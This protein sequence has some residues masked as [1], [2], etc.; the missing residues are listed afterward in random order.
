MIRKITDGYVV[1]VYDDDGNPVSQELVTADF[2]EWERDS[3]DGETENIDDPSGSG[4][5]K[6][7]LVPFEMIQPSDME[8]LIAQLN[9]VV[10]E[11]KKS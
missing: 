4:N 10:T 5:G 2:S 9:P 3:E 1:Q 7:P 11:A 6:F 8:I